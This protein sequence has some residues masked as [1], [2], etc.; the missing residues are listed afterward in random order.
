MSQAQNKY[1]PPD[2][3]GKSSANQ[4]AG[5]NPRKNTVRFELPISAKCHG[6]EKSI[7][8]GVR[9]NAVKT[10]NGSYLSSPIWRFS[11][12]HA[13]CGNPIVIETDPKNTTYIAVEGATF[14]PVVKTEEEVPSNPFEAVERE[15][16]KQKVEKAKELKR[17]QDEENGE[18]ATWFKSSIMSAEDSARATQQMYDEHGD[19]ARLHQDMSYQMRNKFRS[20]KRA[21]EAQDSKDMVLKNKMGLLRDL[22]LAEEA[23]V[24]VP[25]LEKG[26]VAKQDLKLKALTHG[27]LFKEEQGSLARQTK[28]LAK[29]LQA[30]PRQ[31]LKLRGVK[32]NK[33]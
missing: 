31:K 32:K 21:L 33:K 19:K 8:Q 25:S 27:S 14:R 28:E 13:E 16:E 29:T 20:K 11:I 23:Q 6:C 3:D 2:Y 22:Q 30:K 9:F 10:R 1:F 17:E 4:L 12:K 24:I 18:T 7:A 26:L 15:V 5:A